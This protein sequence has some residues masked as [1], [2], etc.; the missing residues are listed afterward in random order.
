MSA[1]SLSLH[2]LLDNGIKPG[3]PNF[4]GGT[5]SCHCPTNKASITLTSDVL[6]NHA[7]GCS[8]CWKPKGAFFSVVGVV[9]ST[10]LS[11]TSNKEKLAII[12]KNAPIQRYACKECG[13]HLFGRIEVDHPFKGLDFV[14]VELSPEGGREGWQAP[15]FA[16]F[17]SS[18]IGQGLDP[19]LVPG[20]RE[21]LRELGIESY[22]AL[23]PGLMDAIA[24]FNAKKEGIVFRASI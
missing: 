19:D 14:H 20:V 17:V 7:C 5:L 9:P 1:S 2:P 18:L 24:T 11:V 6:H 15:Q 16:G 12:D 10:N 13:V 8:K 21:R 23:S 4:P 22:D 3:V